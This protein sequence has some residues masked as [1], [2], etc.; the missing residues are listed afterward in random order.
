MVKYIIVNIVVLDHASYNVGNT[1]PA[2]VYL[3]VCN[4]SDVL[5]YVGNMKPV[6]HIT[7]HNDILHIRPMVNI[8]SA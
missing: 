8:H 7:T 3:C 2:M 1:K 5:C 4:E 6:W